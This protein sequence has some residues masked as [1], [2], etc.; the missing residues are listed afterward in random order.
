MHA[1]IPTLPYSTLHYITLHELTQT[2]IKTYLP[3]YIHTYN[4]P[5]TCRHTCTHASTYTY[6]H[7]YTYIQYMTWHTWHTCTLHKLRDT[8]ACGYMCHCVPTGV[9]ARVD[10]VDR[11]LTL[12]WKSKGRSRTP[13]KR[14]LQRPA[15]ARVWEHRHAQTHTRQA[16]TE[17]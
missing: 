15:Q 12:H 3:T 6:T 1:S 11:D 14:E 4:H 17:N 13:I 7:A 2:N 5:C 8:Y 9:S 16:L 10:W